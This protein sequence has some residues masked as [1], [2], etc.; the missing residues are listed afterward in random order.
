MPCGMN[1]AS[2]EVALVIRRDGEPFMLVLKNG[3][4]EYFTIKRAL[5]QDHVELHGANKVDGE[6]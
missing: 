2:E 4:V 5:Y 6:A 1:R 3:L